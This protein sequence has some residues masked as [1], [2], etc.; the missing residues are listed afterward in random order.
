MSYEYLT[1]I[2]AQM[3]RQADLLLAFHRE[4]SAALEQK[5]ADAEALSA[6]VRQDSTI[7][8]DSIKTLQQSLKTAKAHE[9]EALREQKKAEQAAMRAKTLAATSDTAVLRLQVPKV[10]KEIQKVAAFSREAP[11]EPPLDTLIGPVTINEKALLPAEQEAPAA[12]LPAETIP[13]STL[14]DAEKKG[15]SKRKQTP[16]EP[17]KKIRAYDPAADVLLNPPTPPCRLATERRDAFSGEL[18]RETAPEELF[19]FTNEV[20]KKVL[21]GKTHIRCDAAISG[22]GPR[23]TLRLLFTIHDP[24]PRRTFG[25]L[26]QGGMAVLKFIDGTTHT[27]YNVRADTGT[28][29]P[30]SDTYAFLGVYDIDPATQKKIAA[31]ELDKLRIAWMT[32]YE[33][34]EIY[35]VEVLM[36]QLSCLTTPKP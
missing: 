35:R 12:E 32:G 17:E 3:L 16:A 7:S 28:Q 27:L 33:D 26:A 22:A 5:R 25:G 21:E 15:K 6:Q 9:K 18:Y 13:D 36:R 29:D 4:K 1:E 11:V 19:R 10:F 14:T 23:I 31:Q 30:E 20:M 24:N 34:Y 8:K 2:S